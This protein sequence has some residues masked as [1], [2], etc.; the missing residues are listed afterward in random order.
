MTKE[1]KTY[2]QQELLAVIPNLVQMNL[3]GETTLEHT[4][5]S[6]KLHTPL[7]IC[8]HKRGFYCKL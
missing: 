3:V 4:G 2:I 5:K 1:G 8:C 6:D 7:I